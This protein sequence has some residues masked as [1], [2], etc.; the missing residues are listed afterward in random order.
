MAAGSVGLIESEEFEEGSFSTYGPSL[1]A[2]ASGLE[3]GTGCQVF[4]IG[5]QPKQTTRPATLSPEVEE[6]CY[7]LVELIAT[8]LP[9]PIED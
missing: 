5:I 7:G 9:P 1:A 6:A 3:S 2:F 8:L 4:A